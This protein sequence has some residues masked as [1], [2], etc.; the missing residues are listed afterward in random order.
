[1]GE[2][3]IETRRIGAILKIIAV[4]PVTGTEVSFQAPVTTSQIAL[5]QLAVSKLRYVMRKK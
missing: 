4:D 2:I 3:L 1:M 5:K